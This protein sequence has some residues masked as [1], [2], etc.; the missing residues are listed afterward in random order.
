MFKTL[1]LLEGPR[2]FGPAS[3]VLHYSHTLI[4]H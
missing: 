2:P 1:G 4:I 3:I